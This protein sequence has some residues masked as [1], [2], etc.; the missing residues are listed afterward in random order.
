MRQSNLGL[1]WSTD[2][3]KLKEGSKGLEDSVSGVEELAGEDSD[4]GWFQV[5][6]H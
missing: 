3:G 2:V 6:K 4:L 1:R 5:G